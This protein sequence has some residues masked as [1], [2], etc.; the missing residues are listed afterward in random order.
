MRVFNDF[1]DLKAAVG[2]EVGVSD[3]M[4]ITQDRI[5]KFA[6]ATGDEQWIHV[7]TERAARE[8]PGGT[9]IAH[10]LLS[11]S[12]IPGMVPALRCRARGCMDE[13]GGRLADASMAGS[14]I[15]F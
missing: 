13:S 3:W 2:T 8:S 7:D 12:L 6:E 10:G 14:P 1:N 15:W 9:T 4:E 5:N 11:L